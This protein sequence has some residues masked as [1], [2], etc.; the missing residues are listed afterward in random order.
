MRKYIMA[1][2]QV[3]WS[4]KKEKHLVIL[5]CMWHIIDCQIAV[6]QTKTYISPEIRMSWP[7]CQFILSDKLMAIA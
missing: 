4:F 5:Q 7:H 6:K 2:N 3:V 1:P